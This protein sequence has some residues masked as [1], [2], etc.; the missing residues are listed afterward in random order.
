MRVRRFKLIFSIGV[1]GSW[2]ELYKLETPHPRFIGN[3]FLALRKKRA[4]KVLPLMTGLTEGG[5]EMIINLL[6]QPSGS[7]LS[8]VLTQIILLAG[9]KMED[10]FVSH[11]SLAG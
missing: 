6:T 8:E 10:P 5:A 9:R 1:C 11:I 7:D 3:F 4:R 2:V